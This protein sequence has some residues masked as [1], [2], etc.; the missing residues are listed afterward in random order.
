MST[1][2]NLVNS[3]LI[4][5][6]SNFTT[7]RTKYQQYRYLPHIKTAFVKWSKPETIAGLL[8]KEAFPSVDLGRHLSK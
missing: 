5:L 6:I 8:Y 3:N 4:L 7:I 2:L 1:D